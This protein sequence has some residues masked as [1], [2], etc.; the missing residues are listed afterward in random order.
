[1]TSVNRK[2]ELQRSEEAVSLHGAAAVFK[3][4]E[5]Q[6]Q[7]IFEAPERTKS[8]FPILLEWMK[9]ESLS[10]SCSS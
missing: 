2:Q 7:S 8:F 3:E 4:P 6:P 1:M 10:S 5:Q 9:Y